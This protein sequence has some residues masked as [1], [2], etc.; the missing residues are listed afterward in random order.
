MMVNNTGG[1]KIVKTWH[2]QGTCETV[3]QTEDGRIWHEGQP[4]RWSTATEQ[5]GVMCGGSVFVGWTPREG[6]E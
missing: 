5:T 3:Y 2:G 4:N 1:L 6:K